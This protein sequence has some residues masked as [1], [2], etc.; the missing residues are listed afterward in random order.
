M[1]DL[2]NAGL[3]ELLNDFY[4]LT[5]LKLCVF[6]TDYEEGVHHAHHVPVRHN[7]HA[8]L[9]IVHPVHQLSVFIHEKLLGK[10]V[11]VGV[12]HIVHRQDQ[13]RFPWRR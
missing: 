2:K 10:A 8:A 3:T 1:L 6:D 13:G 9:G 4:T 11:A 7:V 5:D 12:G